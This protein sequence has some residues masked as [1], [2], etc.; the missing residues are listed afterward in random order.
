MRKYSFVYFFGGLYH[1]PTSVGWSVFRLVVRLA[2]VYTDYVDC[3]A[4]SVGTVFQRLSLLLNFPSFIRILMNAVDCCIVLPGVRAR[5]LAIHANICL[6]R[7]MVPHNK[8][9]AQLSSNLYTEQINARINVSYSLLEIHN[10]Q[11]SGL[12]FTPWVCMSVICVTL[13]RLAIIVY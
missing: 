6:I 5:T 4:S 2:K 12:F 9:T 8:I 11:E 1:T 3:Y 10:S 7:S 13:T